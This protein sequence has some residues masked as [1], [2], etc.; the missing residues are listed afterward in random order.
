[1]PTYE[2]IGPAEVFSL[3]EHLG[4][5]MAAR[6]W[7]VED[8]ALRMGGDFGI[9]ALALGLLLAVQEDNLIIDDDTIVRLAG[10]FDVSPDLFRNL[11]AIWLKYPERRSPYVMPESLLGPQVRASLDQ[12]NKLH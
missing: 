10:A 12:M 6:G 5:E 1:M 9:D 8:V 4:D 7:T 2:E 3:A 11:H